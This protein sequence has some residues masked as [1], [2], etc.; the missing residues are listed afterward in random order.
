MRDKNL[1][2]VLKGQVPVWASDLH[3][4]WRIVNIGIL[5]RDECCYGDLILNDFVLHPQSRQNRKQVRL[6]NRLITHAW[7][8]NLSATPT[9]KNKEHKYLRLTSLEYNKLIYR[10]KQ[11]VPVYLLLLH[12][13]IHTSFS[14]LQKGLHTDPDFVL[15]DVWKAF[16]S[17]RSVFKDCIP[18]NSTPAALNWIRG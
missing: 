7:H 6:F 1:A 12:K 10:V 2:A 18:H 9:Q 4:V 14:D 8:R 17:P 13:R 11:F 3:Q 5:Q 15:H 16:G